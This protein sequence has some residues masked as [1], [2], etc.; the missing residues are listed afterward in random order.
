MTILPAWAL[1]A[2]ERLKAATPRPWTVDEDAPCEFVNS[3]HG[4]LAELHLTRY[5]N[6]ALI[7]HAPTDLARALDALESAER[8][9][10]AHKRDK[11]AWVRTIAAGMPEKERLTAQQFDAIGEE[12]SEAESAHRASMEAVD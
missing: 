9:I 3:P 2:R 10:E 7:A 12:V 4:C 1:A 5:G 11:A 6:A 8:V